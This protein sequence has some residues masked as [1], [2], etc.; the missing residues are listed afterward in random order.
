MARALKVLI[1]AQM[2]PGGVWGGVEQVLIGLVCA[3]G[4]LKDG[5]ESYILITSPDHPDWLKPHLGPN[6]NIVTFPRPN[7][8]RWEWAKRALG[9]LRRPMGELRLAL[10]RYCAGQPVRG[11]LP[12]SGGF[13]ESLGGDVIHFPNQ[14]FMRCSLPSIYNP[15]D[16]QHLHYPQFFPRKAIAGREVLYRG[17]CRDSQAVAAPSWAVKS[18]LQQQYGLAAEKVF[19]VH[20]AAPVAL[21]EDVPHAVVRDV[22]GK[23]KV[24]EVFAFYPAQTWPHKNHLRLLEALRLVRDREGVRL[25][26]V[27]TGRKNEHWPAI[28]RRIEELDLGAQV[29]FLGF[30]R[31]SDVRALYH[32]AQFVVYPSLFEGAGMPVVEAFQEG[33]AV[34][35]SDIPSL[36]EYG[37][38]AVLAFDPNSADSIAASLLRIASDAGLRAQLRARGSERVQLF[39]WER[40]AKTYR[41]LYR[42]VAGARLSEEDS[43][44]LASETMCEV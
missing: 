37:A 8:G 44:L 1:N 7:E 4:R 41:A 20:Q 10:R 33:V 27:C 17:A 42:K 35:C 22:R 5:N 34:T 3:L 18:D 14:Q 26:L 23:F 15:W 19:V 29:M 2:P 36:R 31:A 32:L 11:V 16:L 25:N 30:V 6:Q 21:Y 28:Q 24:P 43:H 38:D 9:P 13:F 12:Q 39:T 40:T